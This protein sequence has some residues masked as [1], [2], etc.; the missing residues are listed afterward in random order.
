N[1]LKDAFEAYENAYSLGL[2]SNHNIARLG[3]IAEK[4][5]EYDKAQKYLEKAIENNPKRADIILSYA[6]C[7]NKQGESL[8]AAQVLAVLRDSSNSYAIKKAA[9]QEYQKIIEEENKSNQ[10]KPDEITSSEASKK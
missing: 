1:K 4:I 9:E 2:D 8:A 6:R 3:I 7:L 5:G 10:N